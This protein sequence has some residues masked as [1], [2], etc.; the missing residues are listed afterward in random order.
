MRFRIDTDHE[1]DRT[2]LKV[3]GTLR[4]PAV[5]ELERVCRQADGRLFVDLREVMTVD[6]FGVVLLNELAA[7]GARLVGASPYVK[8]LLETQTA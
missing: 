3:S 7:K 6:G 2:T 1:E 5:D 8:L 4:G